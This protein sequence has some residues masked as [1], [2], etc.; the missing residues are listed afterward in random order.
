ME[1]RFPRITQIYTVGEKYVFKKG[2][3]W[4]LTQN[5]EISKN[6]TGD[7][8]VAPTIF[9]ISNKKSSHHFAFSWCLCAFA[10]KFPCILRQDFENPFREIQADFIL[11]EYV[12][13]QHPVQ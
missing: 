7:Q 2:L 13:S 11:A 1:I 6:N 4:V 3:N 9:C 10:R 5:F 8:P 12:A